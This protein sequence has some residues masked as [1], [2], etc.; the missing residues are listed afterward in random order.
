MLGVRSPS[1][2]RP[3]LP[4]I[5]MGRGQYLIGGLR[6]GCLGWI[7]LRNLADAVAVKTTLTLMPIEALEVVCARQRA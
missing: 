7:C 2:A 4:D 3:K 6:R 5:R 1:G